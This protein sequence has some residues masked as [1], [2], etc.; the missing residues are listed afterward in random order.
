MSLDDSWFTEPTDAEGVAFSLRV[1][2]KLHDERTPYQ[3]IEVYQTTHWGRLLT[4]DGC[5]MLT[6]RD[7]F[8]YHEMMA[9][10][11]LFSHRDPRSVLIIGGGDCGT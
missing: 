3:H 2:A 6:S 8:L 5:V 9:H 4:I 10:P 11:A 1:S 7:N